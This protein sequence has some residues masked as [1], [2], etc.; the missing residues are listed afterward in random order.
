MTR[1]TLQ[2]WGMTSY[3]H[4]LLPGTPGSVERP[5]TLV[6]GGNE[7]VHECGAELVEAQVRGGSRSVK[8]IRR[9]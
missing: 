6:Q 4:A 8:A 9:R 1:L 5:V 3:P 7:V 2:R